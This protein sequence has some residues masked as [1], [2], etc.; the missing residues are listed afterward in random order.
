MERRTQGDKAVI[1][2]GRL[3]TFGN[4][5]TI[6]D[7]LVCH[8]VSPWDED[9]ERFKAIELAG[10]VKDRPGV[11]RDVVTRR[12]GRMEGERKYQCRCEA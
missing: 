6:E 1:N 11:D 3:G 9:R 8:L 7:E 12:M 2:L 10:E 4:P 5:A